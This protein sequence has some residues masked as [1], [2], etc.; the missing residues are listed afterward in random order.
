MNTLFLILI[1]TML[2]NDAADTEVPL[3]STTSVVFASRDEGKSILTTRDDFVRR[4]S[5]FD[6]AARIQ[7]AEAVS[8]AE[9]LEFVGSHL[10]PW[11][12]ADKQKVT[13]ALGALRTRLSAYELPLPEKV[14]M[15]CTS[16]AEEGGAAYTRANAIIL[17]KGMLREPSALAR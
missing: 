14:Y 10:R 15:I 13:T 1:C 6:R 3:T 8:E 7:T 4:M 5:A 2:P 11:D 12:E 9:Y 16:G 17:P